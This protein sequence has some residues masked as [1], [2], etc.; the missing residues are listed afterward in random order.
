MLLGGAI[1]AGC[2]SLPPVNIEISDPD[3]IWN[4]GGGDYNR[5]SYTPTGVSTN[6]RLL[7][8]RSFKRGLTVEP[9]AAFGKI[10][11]PTP[12]RKLHII[13]S[14]D[15]SEILSRRYKEE[16][17][18]PVIIVDSL[19]VLSIN[20]EKLV[21]ENWID[22][23]TI[24]EADLNGSFLE[25]LVMDN[26]VFWIDGKNYLRCYRIGDGARV[27]DRRLEYHSSSTMT[28]F[29]GAVVLAGDDGVIHCLESSSGE[30]LWQYDTGHRMRN[31]PV[32]VDGG[33]VYCG[34]EGDIGL[35]DASDG[36]LKWRAELESTVL[37]PLA[38]DENS[39]FVGANDRY[40][41]RIDL[42]SGDVLWKKRVGGPVKAGPTLTD[43]MAVFVGIDYRAY[44]VDKK[45]GGVIYEFK[46][47][48]MLT[49]RPLACEDRVFIAGEDRNLYCFD[50]SGEN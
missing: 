19:T 14:F 27:W 23:R 37:A 39:I 43:K 17:V 44:F 15:G 38:A 3:C 5:A 26:R 45:T 35:L 42:V 46:A 9:T 25:P 33:I 50:I 48:G 49:T 34:P 8:T 13:S 36:S 21:V 20:G 6:A 2:G 28:G 4:Q 32:Y 22:H 7:W 47:N 1:V 24:W 12:D 29:A 11:I 41:Y 10:L 40:I 30:P 31:E 18:N 16:I